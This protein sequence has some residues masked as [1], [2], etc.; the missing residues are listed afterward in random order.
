VLLPAH[1]IALE[2]GTFTAE[3]RRFLVPVTDGRLDVRFVNR[4]GAGKAEIGAI[5]VTQRPDR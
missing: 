1:D 2:V 4:A 3:H 5:R